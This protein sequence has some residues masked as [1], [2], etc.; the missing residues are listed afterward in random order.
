MSKIQITCET[1]DA[2]IYYSTDGSDS[3]N[4]Y[5]EPFELNEESTIKARAKKTGYNDS[6]LASFTAEKL[7]TPVIEE[8]TISNQGRPI[9]FVNLNNSKEYPEEGIIYFRDVRDRELTEADSWKTTPIK[10]YYSDG[11]SISIGK[12]FSD[13]FTIYYEVYIKCKNYLDSEHIKGSL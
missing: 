9:T 13:D 7:I 4:L 1:Q 2:Q 12:N 3:S 5:S 10:G 11:A 6:D 8:H